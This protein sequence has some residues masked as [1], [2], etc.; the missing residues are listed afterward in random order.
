MCATVV[1]VYASPKDCPRCLVY[2]LDTY[3]SKL[4]AGGADLEAFYLQPLKTTPKNA[5]EPWY[6]QTPVGKET[7]CKYLN[8]MCKEAGLNGKT[9]QGLLLCLRLMF[10]RR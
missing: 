4:P 1:P 7:L 10:Q 6:R 5:N 3:L 9:N 8:A 2:L